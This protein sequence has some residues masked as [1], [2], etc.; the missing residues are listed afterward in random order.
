MTCPELGA[1]V[2]FENIIQEL[3]H[4]VWTVVQMR[5]QSTNVHQ[6]TW[7]LNDEIE[8]RKALSH[9]YPVHE[10]SADIICLQNEGRFHDGEELIG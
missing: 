1:C 8:T 2:W 9:L 5:I 6:Y 4:A 10:N 7:Q 3:V